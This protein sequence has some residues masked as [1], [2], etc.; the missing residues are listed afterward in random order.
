M[1]KE[2]DRANQKD[3][4][5]SIR[6]FCK[7][8]NRLDQEIEHFLI[9]ASKEHAGSERDFREFAAEY[10]GEY[11]THFT[12]KEGLCLENTGN[13]WRLH[14]EILGLKVYA[15][16]DQ[17]REAYLTEPYLNDWEEDLP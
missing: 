17:S 1:T 7:L 15:E 6:D 12:R 5:V 3:C 4:G 13:A 2:P 11:K 9:Q 8:L 10:W 16:A 14:T